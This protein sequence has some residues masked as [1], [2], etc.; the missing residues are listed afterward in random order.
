MSLLVVAPAANSTAGQETVL[1]IEQGAVATIHIEGYPDFL[2]I[3]FGSLWVSNEGVG[4]VQRIDARTNKIIGQIKI[5]EPCAAMAA[6]YRSIWVASCKDKAILRI[7][8]ETTYFVKGQ[9][10]RMIF[11]R[12]EQGRVTSLL[13]RQ[14]AQDLV[15]K[16][17]K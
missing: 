13:F 8:N 5:N 2:E 7:E 10:W 16:K 6:G 17:I 14:H 4:A 1:P 3:A 9:D 12:D 15:A 11:V